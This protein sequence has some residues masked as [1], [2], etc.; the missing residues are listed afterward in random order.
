MGLLLLL[1]EKS[2]TPQNK[3]FQLFIVHKIIEEIKSKLFERRKVYYYSF[4]IILFNIYSIRF[5]F[6]VHEKR[7]NS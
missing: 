6:Q 2:K 5:F 3:L 4:F 1:P 7:T